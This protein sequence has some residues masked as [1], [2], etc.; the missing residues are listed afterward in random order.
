MVNQITQLKNALGVGARANKYKVYFSFPNAVAPIAGVTTEILSL[1]CHNCD[2]FPE[3]SVG[4]SDIFVQGRK[5]TIPKQGEN[6]GTWS[7]TFYNDEEHKFRNSFLAWERAIDHVPT[8]VSTGNVNDVMTSLKVAQL[9]SANNETVV[10]TFYNVFVSSVGSIGFDGTSA[11]DPETFQVTFTYSYY[12][13]GVN[14]DA[15]SDN[16]ESFNSATKNSSAF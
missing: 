13:S 10:Y 6:G 14:A 7:A 3:R 1:I 9:D 16:I 15:D 11:A 8:N 5:V 4:S 12:T 2:G